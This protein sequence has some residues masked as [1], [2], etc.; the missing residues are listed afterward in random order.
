MLSQCNGV[1][2]FDGEQLQFEHLS[3]VTNCMMT[4]SV[5]LPPQ[6]RTQPVPVLWWL[7][8]LTCTDQNFVTK[9]GA[10]RYAAEHGVAIVAPDTSPRGPGVPT[11]PDG[12][13]D[14]GHGAGFYVD[15]TEAPWAR[16]YQMHSYIRDELPGL[17]SSLP[18]DL[19]RQSIAG[20][21]MG[22]HGA[23]VMALR[24]HGAFRSVSAFAPIVAPSQVS[25][26]MKAFG[27]LLGDPKTW[28]RW[29]AT[30]LVEA[31]LTGSH[32][33]MLIDQ[34]TA[35]PFL[36]SQLQPW[37]LEEACKLAGHPIELRMRDG[38]DHSYHFVSSFIGEHIAW[39]A[40]A[41]KRP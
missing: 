38:Y 7:S 31:E 9:A 23:L 20:H 12:A 22:G 27:N 16:H 29:D 19:S 24:N 36:D 2:C 11:D 17:L 10:Q 8:G 28:A 26:G 25:W 41:L 15:A 40:A 32:L 37:K 13:W 21:S 35:D 33:R 39:H 14:F 6:A 1:R 5:Y 3:T 4:L 30:R 18:L 34:G